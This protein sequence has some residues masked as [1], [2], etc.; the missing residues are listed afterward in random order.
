MFTVATVQ[1]RWHPDARAYLARKRAEG[2]TPAEARRCLKRHLAAVIYRAMH[3]DPSQRQG[4]SVNI[5]D[6][7]Q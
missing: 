5:P 1:A 2:K 7:V 3:R 6:L 4:H